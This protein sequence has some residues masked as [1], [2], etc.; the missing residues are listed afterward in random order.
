MH[1][2]LAPL[3]WLLRSPYGLALAMLFG[4]VFGSFAN[5]CIHRI[6][7]RQSLVHPPSHCP[8]CQTPIA[9][10][11]NIPV[12]G[13]LWLLGRCRHCRARVPLRYLIIELLAIAGSALVY[14]RFVGY[15][16]WAGPPAVVLA[17]YIV[18]FFFTLTLLILSAIDVEHQLLP[19]RIT[20]PAI[21]LF[22]LLGQL[23]AWQSSGVSFWQ[24]LFGVVLGY[25]IVRVISDGY[26][27]LTGR[28]G[29]GYGDGKLL[30]MIGAL[31]GWRAL[32][33]TLLVGSLSGLIV[34]VPLALWLRRGKKDG[35]PLFQLKLVFGPFL[36]FGAFVYLMLLVGRDV[37][38]LL[39]WLL[40]PLFGEAV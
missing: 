8:Q 21:P 5:V 2:E 11:D 38:G 19:D 13:Y 39:L 25:G 16:H 27:Y 3:T 33:Y 26:Y 12:L 29:L 1:S 10:R 32:P 4:A 22:L 30:A 31:L 15:G 36:A 24:A 9:W 28:E 23:V 7:R 14:A 34:G 37:D 18:Y 17:Q 40:A 20:Y 6:P 35:T